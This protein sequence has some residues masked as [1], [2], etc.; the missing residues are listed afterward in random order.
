MSRFRTALALG[1]TT[2]L[3]AT[4]FPAIKVGVAG[5]GVAG[6]SFSRLL[7][8]SLALAFVAP[9]LKVRLPRVRDLPLIAGCGA[10]GMSA[11]QVLLN[12]GEVNVPAGTASL[13]VAVAPVFS[14]L[15]AATFLGERLSVRVALGSLVAL[16]GSAL[17]ALSGGNTGYSAAAW[18]VLG[19][20]AVQGL[21][22]FASKP[23]LARYTAMEVACYATWSGTLFLAPLAPAAFQ[24]VT[25]TGLAAVLS[26][27]FL[28]L[29]PSAVGFV[30]WGYAVARST[31]AAATAA[32]YLVPVIAV[33][34]SFLWLRERPTVVE[35][36]GG[37][38]SILGVVLIRGI[39]RTGRAAPSPAADQVRP[40]LASPSRLRA[41]VSSAAASRDGQPPR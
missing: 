17:I 8:A 32:L 7:V 22:H 31:M 15:L 24:A 5:F 16:G 20:A 38:I 36:V 1:L 23:L 33:G 41:P 27:V 6:L 12:W 14:V 26:V 13:L 11:Y 21:Y 34:V 18:V 28:G 37:I 29:L 9:A 19:A 3:W 25:T 39:G 40:E 10:A 35:I 30:A 2:V 4:A